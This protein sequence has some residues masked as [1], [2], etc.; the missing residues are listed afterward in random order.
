MRSY[1]LRSCSTK[2]Y[3]L[4]MVGPVQVQNKI[5]VKTAHLG[6][7]HRNSLIKALT[8]Q[9]LCIQPELHDLC[10]VLC[11]SHTVQKCQ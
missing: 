8:W 1:D 2:K 10:L 5:S 7:I 3:E 11:I 9:A 4:D 6:D